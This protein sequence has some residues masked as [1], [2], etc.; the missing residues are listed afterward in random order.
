MRFGSAPFGI[1]K[2]LKDSGHT[3]V[4]ITTLAEEM[5]VAEAVE[6]SALLQKKLGMSVAGVI[7]NQVLPDLEGRGTRRHRGTLP[8][9]ARVHQSRVRLQKDF[10][11]QL[12]KE[13]AGHPFWK[14]PFSFAER[15]TL[16]E[17]DRLARV[18]FSPS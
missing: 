1:E 7:V 18:A 14:V 9:W 2:M 11:I 17:I 3:E 8:E 6:L 10:I 5:P 12:E 15:M 4:L 13:L 16:A